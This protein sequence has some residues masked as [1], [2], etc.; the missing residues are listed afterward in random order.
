ML[1]MP[2]VDLTAMNLNLLVAL[3]ALLKTRSVTRAAEKLGVTQSAMSHSLRQLRAAFE[4]ELLVRTGAGLIMTPRAERLAARLGPGLDALKAAL[5]DDPP[6]DP[7]SAT[8]RFSLISGDFL[9]V[10]VLPALLGILGGEAPQ[11]DLDVSTTAR[12]LDA[13]HYLG[14]LER[15]E[16]DLLVGA[17]VAERPAIKRRVLHTER[18]ACLLRADHPDVKRT[19]TLAR[20]TRLGH[21]LIVTSGEGPSVVDT[22]LAALG[23]QRRVAVRVA[24]FLAAP[25]AVA[26]SDLILTAPTS[27]AVHFA[28]RYPL[29]VLPPPLELPS[30]DVVQLWHER[31]DDD[32]GHAWLRGAVAR[33]SKGVLARW[34][35]DAAAL[36]A[37]W[38]GP[39][40]SRAGG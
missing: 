29:R 32:P 36:D 5:Q 17:L 6:F 18:F 15:G 2:D 21:V 26:A 19:L 37:G 38:A 20:Y 8:R 3:E 16:T 1:M 23:R 33:A 22:R 9:A 39:R 7:R 24:S 4:D 31:M 34:Q 14:R 11:V 40:L 30:F 13:A 27:L 12:G 25:M 10:G 35:E 28:R